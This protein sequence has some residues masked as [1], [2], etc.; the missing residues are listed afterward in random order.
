MRHCS[1]LDQ[2]GFLSR[3]SPH[4]PVLIPLGGE[5][6]AGLLTGSLGLVVRRASEPWR[7]APVGLGLTPFRLLLVILRGR[8]APRLGRAFV[9]DDWGTLGLGFLRVPHTQPLDAVHRRPETPPDV[10]WRSCRGWLLRVCGG[11]GG[12]RASLIRRAVAQRAALRRLRRLLY[13]PLLSQRL[14]L[15]LLLLGVVGRL[16]RRLLLL[17]VLLPRRPLSSKQGAVLGRCIQGRRCSRRLGPS[18]VRQRCCHA[19]LQPPL[20]LLAFAPLGSAAAG[21]ALAARI[22]LGVL[23]LAPSSPLG[24]EGRPRGSLLPLQPLSRSLPRPSPA[25]VPGLALPPRGRRWRFQRVLARAGGRC[26][27]PSGPLAPPAR[28]RDPE[29]PR[30]RSPCRAVAAPPAAGFPRRRPAWAEGPP[31]RTALWKKCAPGGFAHKPPKARFLHTVPM[32]V[33]F[34]AN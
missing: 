33:A 1:R 5:R 4:P 16:L 3:A 10:S 30:P 31:T 23:P 20:L 24:L 17:A 8:E 11:L 19:R 14:L 27:A 2:S 22:P 21:C 7:G 29:L 13:L 26:P 18:G 28:R 6:S 12:I 34:V 15:L 32:F 9:F 25:L